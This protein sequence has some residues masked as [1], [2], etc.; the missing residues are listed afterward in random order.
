[1]RPSIDHALGVAHD[2]V[3]AAHAQPDVVRRA[4]NRRRAGAVEDH[5]DVF[6]L[7]AA[8]FQ[9]VEQARAADDRR[10]VLVVVEDR[11]LHGLAQRLFDVEAL[12][13]LDVFQVDAAEGRLQN[14]AGA[15]DLLRIFGV[16]LDIEHVDIGEALEEDRLA[17]HHRLAGQRADIAQAEHGGAVGDHADQVALGGV[18]V[19]EAGVALDFQAGNGDARRVGQAEIALRAAGLGGDHRQLAGGR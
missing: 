10:A 8:E 7:L 3:L 6:D 13:R 9:R 4:G 18:F 16:Q 2:D 11:N 19:G 15:D 14:L 12:R 1:M 17:F 5:L